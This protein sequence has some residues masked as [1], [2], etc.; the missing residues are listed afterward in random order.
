MV[1]KFWILCHWEKPIDRS[2]VHS[3][4]VPLA[5]AQKNKTIYTQEKSHDLIFQTTAFSCKKFTSYK[6]SAIPKNLT[7]R[8]YTQSKNS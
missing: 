1:D 6:L 3:T 7:Q 4:V 8:L 2:W 5:I